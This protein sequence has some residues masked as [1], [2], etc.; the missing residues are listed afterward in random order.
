MHQMKIYVGLHISIGK[1]RRHF[2]HSV[3]SRPFYDFPEH[4]GV[5]STSVMYYQYISMDFKGANTMYL[6]VQKYDAQRH[7]KQKAEKEHQFWII[8]SLKQA[9]LWND[10]VFHL[11]TNGGF[12]YGSSCKIKQIQKPTFLFFFFFQVSWTYRPQR[13]WKLCL[14]LLSHGLTSWSP[15]GKLTLFS[16]SV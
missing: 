14:E 9:I 6:H 11:D 7:L 16:Y 3:L 13:V 1:L 15:G 8:S 4:P 5:P 10:I 2:L 12:A